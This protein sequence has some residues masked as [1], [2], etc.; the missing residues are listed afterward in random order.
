[1]ICRLELISC[2]CML[3]YPDNFNHTMQDTGSGE[4]WVWGVWGVLTAL[5]TSL[6]TLQVKYLFSGILE[7][8]MFE[9]WNA[10]ISAAA[11]LG[12]GFKSKP[13]VHMYFM[14]TFSYTARR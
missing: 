12:T 5:S 3:A 8:R 7:A 6:Q 10:C 14:L 13:E 4:R 1:M 11:I 2:Q 9:V